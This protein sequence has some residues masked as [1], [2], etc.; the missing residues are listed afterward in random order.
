MDRSSSFM[1]PNSTFLAI[2][3][4]ASGKVFCGRLDRWV[5]CRPDDF[6]GHGW[7]IVFFWTVLRTV[8]KLRWVCLGGFEGIDQ[9]EAKAKKK[10]F[11]SPKF[12]N[13]PPEKGPFQEGNDRKCQNG[14]GQISGPYD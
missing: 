8:G 7:G 13:M 10:R 9:D 4:F 2:H 11:P 1:S 5:R 14:V 6:F 12:T 3:R